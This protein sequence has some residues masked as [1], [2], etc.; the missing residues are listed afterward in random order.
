[1]Q[2][3][4]HAIMDGFELSAYACQELDEAGFTVVPGPVPT[5]DLVRLA[6][7]P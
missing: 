7:T 5:M 2:D 4:A 3:C 1:M 6:A